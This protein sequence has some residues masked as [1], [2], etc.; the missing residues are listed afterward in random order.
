MVTPKQTSSN[1]DATEDVQ[2]LMVEGVKMVMC[3]V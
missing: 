3:C 2:V 1:C